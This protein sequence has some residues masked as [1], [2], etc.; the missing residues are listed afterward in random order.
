MVERIKKK[1][2]ALSATETVEKS[3]AGRAQ[4]YVDH[5]HTVT[6]FVYNMNVKHVLVSATSV[7]HAGSHSQPLSSRD[8]VQIRDCTAAVLNPGW[9]VVK[10][11]LWF[12]SSVTLRVLQL[13]RVMSSAGEGSEEGISNSKAYSRTVSEMFTSF[14]WALNQFCW[15]SIDKQRSCTR[16]VSLC[17]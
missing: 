12:I 13:N 16:I 8:T 6:V 15:W 1:G 10:L 3:I 11:D 7:K 14:A 9:K 5:L 2:W 17:L 4:D